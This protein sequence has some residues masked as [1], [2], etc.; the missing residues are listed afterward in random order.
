MNSD[1]L[2]VDELVLQLADYKHDYADV[3]AESCCAS[4]RVRGKHQYLK[5]HMHDAWLPDTQDN[6]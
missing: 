6:N 2:E 5:N 3:A 1:C 4:A